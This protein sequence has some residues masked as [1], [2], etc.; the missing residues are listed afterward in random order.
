[1]QRNDAAH[2]ASLKDLPQSRPPRRQRDAQAPIVLPGRP[3]VAYLRRPLLVSQFPGKRVDLSIVTV[4][5]MM[6]M[7]MMQKATMM[8]MAIAMLIA[9]SE[10]VLVMERGWRW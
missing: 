6:M 10:K 4:M 2:L 9:R 3:R 5:M 1:M 7:M 8:A